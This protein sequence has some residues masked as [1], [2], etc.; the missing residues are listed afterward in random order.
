MARSQSINVQEHFKSTQRQNV[1]RD[2]L[3]GLFASL[4]VG[5]AASGLLMLVIILFMGNV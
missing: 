4:G 2:A 5:V 3:V 1:V